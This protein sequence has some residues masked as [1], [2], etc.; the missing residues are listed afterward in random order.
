MKNITIAAVVLAIAPCLAHAATI[1]RWVD[2]QGRMHIAD[3]VPDRYKSGATK[4]DSKQFELSEDERAA[5][6]A[7]LAKERAR[8]ADAQRAQ[9]EAVKT[10]ASNPSPA[11]SSSAPRPSSAGSGTECDRLWQAYFESQECFAPYQSRNRGTKAEAFDRCHPAENPSQ[12]CGPA[13]SV[14]G[15]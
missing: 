4:V 13:K 1:Y 6:A 5:A 9:A 11:A 10:S 14:K 15:A 3:T 7:R 12:R 8:Q 2:D